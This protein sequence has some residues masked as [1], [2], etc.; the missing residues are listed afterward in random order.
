MPQLA[1]ERTCAASGMPV[2][3]IMSG[4]R[5]F[6]DISKRAPQA[7]EW[8]AAVQDLSASMT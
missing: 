8:G 5:I 3:N 1:W 6:L 7:K 4:R 2:G